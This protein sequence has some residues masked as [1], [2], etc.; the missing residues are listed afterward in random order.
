MQ[1]GKIFKDV[2]L[3]II[4]THIP[5]EKELKLQKF[6]DWKDIMCIVENYSLLIDWLFYSFYLFSSLFYPSRPL[7]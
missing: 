1:E 3:R 2:L 7:F 5:Y 6:A 4:D